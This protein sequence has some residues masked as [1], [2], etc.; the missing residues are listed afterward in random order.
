M[1]LTFRIVQ[2]INSQKSQTLIVMAESNARV[3]RASAVEWLVRSWAVW[4]QTRLHCQCLFPGFFQ[5]PLQLGLISKRNSPMSNKNSHLHGFLGDEN[6]AG[7]TQF[8]KNPLLL[9]HKKCIYKEVLLSQLF[10]ILTR[11][12]RA[13]RTPFFS[14]APVPWVFLKRTA[15]RYSEAI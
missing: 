8:Q 11:F 4:I 9:P 14:L 7:S 15:K 12:T 1:S 3:L 2:I 10:E 5:A 13:P 6:S